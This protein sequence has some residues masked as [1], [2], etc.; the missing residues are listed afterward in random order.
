VKGQFDLYW[1]GNLFLSKDV[2]QKFFTIEDVQSKLK[3]KG[4]GFWMEE[5]R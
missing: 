5:Q 2:L 1:N 3:E 4:L